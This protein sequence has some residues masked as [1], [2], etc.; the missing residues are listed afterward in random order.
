MMRS[1][2][3]A[4]LAACCCVCLRVC[5][6]GRGVVSTGA[7]DGAG[8]NVECEGRTKKDDGSS[9]GWRF[10]R[11][12]LVVQKSRGPT[13]VN[14]FCLVFPPCRSKSYHHLCTVPQHPSAGVYLGTRAPGC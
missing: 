12:S 4:L 2:V 9:R 14:D 6:C 8:W 7:D 3:S 11:Q 5:G 1:D 13:H 10:W